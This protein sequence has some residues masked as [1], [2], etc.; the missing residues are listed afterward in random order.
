MDTD[1]VSPEGNAMT[2]EQLRAE[3]KALGYRLHR[4]PPSQRPE[5]IAAEKRKVAELHAQGMS[6]RAISQALR[7]H[8]RIVRK[9]VAGLMPVI[10]KPWETC[11]RLGCGCQFLVRPHSNRLFCSRECA[12]M[13]QAA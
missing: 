7:M 8:R 2:L 11:A 5:H 3:A 1:E 6:L 12:T 13:K 9:Y 4:L 10:E